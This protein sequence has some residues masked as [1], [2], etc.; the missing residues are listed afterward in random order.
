MNYVHRDRSVFEGTLDF[1][2]VRSSFWNFSNR[3][4]QL[5]FALFCG[6]IICIIIP[7]AKEHYIANIFFD[8]CLI[9]AHYKIFYLCSFDLYHIIFVVNYKILHLCVKWLTIYRFVYSRLISLKLT[10]TLRRSSLSLHAWYTCVL[11]FKKENWILNAL[12]FIRHF[13]RLM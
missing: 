9:F 3:D 1:E 7:F 12:I 5:T 13:K 2:S 8:V 6:N 4:A 11:V 10:I